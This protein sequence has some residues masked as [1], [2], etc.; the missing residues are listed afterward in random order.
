MFGYCFDSVSALPVWE[1]DL[2]ASSFE[3][4]SLDRMRIVCGARDGIDVDGG[5]PHAPTGIMQRLAL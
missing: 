3:Q 1:V 4:P 5:I 2:M